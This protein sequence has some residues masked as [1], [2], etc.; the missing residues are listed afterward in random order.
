MCGKL[1]SF[2]PAAHEHWV[3]APITSGSVDDSGA[4]P[5]IRFTVDARRLSVSP[6][7]GV[8]DRDQAEVQSNMQNKVLES[9]TYPEIVF[10]LDADSTN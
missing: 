10:P 6:E 3:N 1:A 2:P 7:K 4:T 8:S 5:G 9:S